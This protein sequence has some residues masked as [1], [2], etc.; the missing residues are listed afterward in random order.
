MGPTIIQ[1]DAFKQPLFFLVAEGTQ[2][3]YRIFALKPESRMHELVGEL[4]RAGQKEQP[5]GIEVQTTNRLPF[6]LKKFG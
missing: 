5:L 2:H 3:S 6:A 1:R 4:A